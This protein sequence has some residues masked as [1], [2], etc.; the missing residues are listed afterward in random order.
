MLASGITT[1]DVK[2]IYDQ[3]CAKLGE[4]LIWLKRTVAIQTAY[5]A[6]ISTPACK[7][8][9][10]PDLYQKQICVGPL[11]LFRAITT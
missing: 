1:D 10:L 3:T 5:T 9:L 7:Y 6:L 8:G 4:R 11:W 2:S